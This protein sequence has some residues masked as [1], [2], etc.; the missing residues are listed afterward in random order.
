[1]ATEINAI[2]IGGPA[3]TQI[4]R[5]QGV[6]RVAKF[7]VYRGSRGYIN[8]TYTGGAGFVFAEENAD[9][10]IPRSAPTEHSSGQMDRSRRDLSIRGL[11][12][13]GRPLLSVKPVS[14]R[15]D[16]HLLLLLD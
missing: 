14:N 16:H 12:G 2:Y 8:S 13:G 15:G 6:P 11:E 1:M 5:I 4:P 7:H 10:A 9:F 3:G